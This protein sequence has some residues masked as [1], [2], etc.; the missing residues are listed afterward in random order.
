MKDYK[1][2]LAEARDAMQVLSDEHIKDALD[3]RK[4]ADDEDNGD[5]ASDARWAR[6]YIGMAIDCIEN[7]EE[8]MDSKATRRRVS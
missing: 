4:T 2:I 8:R 3:A 7:I 5:I 6:D 1:P